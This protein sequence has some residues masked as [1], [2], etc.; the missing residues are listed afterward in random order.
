VAQGL[1]PPGH[2]QPGPG[3][4]ERDHANTMAPGR[5]VPGLMPAGQGAS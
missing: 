5:A 4:A 1:I 2:V 3:P